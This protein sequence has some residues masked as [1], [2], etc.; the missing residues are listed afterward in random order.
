MWQSE[1]IDR[2]ADDF[3]QRINQDTA[4]MP[5]YTLKRACTVLLSTTMM[6]FGPTLTPAQRI[7]S[8]RGCSVESPH[9][10][11]YPVTKRSPRGA[12]AVLLTDPHVSMDGD[13]L[14][15]LGATAGET[16]DA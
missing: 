3:T 4:T 16:P 13:T 6:K 12:T 7:G 8:R 11:S 10:V 9:W 14:D 1:V 15:N 2:I 5:K